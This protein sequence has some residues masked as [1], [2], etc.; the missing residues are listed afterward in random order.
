ME[1]SRGGNTG[2]SL[3]SSEQ[4]QEQQAGPSHEHLAALALAGIAQDFPPASNS[5]KPQPAEE[6]GQNEEEG[7]QEEEEE[8]EAGGEGM[9][10]AASENDR[11][12]AAGDEPACSRQVAVPGSWEAQG[13]LTIPAGKWAAAV[14]FTT[15]SFNNAS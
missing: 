5:D 11:A 10:T 8:E 14:G 4:E 9:G 12:G 1:P 6:E 15:F 7:E 3:D 13:R 2:E